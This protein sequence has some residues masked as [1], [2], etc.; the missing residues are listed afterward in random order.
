[1][2]RLI[3]LLLVITLVIL[4]SGCS[5]NDID[6]GHKVIAGAPELLAAQAAIT[7]DNDKYNVDDL[8]TVLFNYGQTYQDNFDTGLI[9]GH[10]VEVLLTD[11][12]EGFLIPNEYSIIYSIDFDG[13]EFIT[14]ENECTSTWIYGATIHFNQEFSLD[15]DFSNLGYSEGMLLIRIAEYTYEGNLIDNEEVLTP[16]TG[17][18]SAYVYF[19]VEDEKV[20]FSENK[21]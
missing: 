21:F 15:I 11:D 1:M 12:L 9:D 7:I 8:V 10:S 14:E 5:R 19:K 3:N 6:V 2:K 13:T 17:Y 16:S 20:Y 18:T 4:I